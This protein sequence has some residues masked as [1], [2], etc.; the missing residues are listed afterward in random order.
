MILRS[1]YDAMHYAYDG[2]E[3]LHDGLVDNLGN[4]IALKTFWISYHD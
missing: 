2:S 1:L 4:D 3:S